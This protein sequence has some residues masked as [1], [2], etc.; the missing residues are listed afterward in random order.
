MTAPPMAKTVDERQGKLRSVSKGY[1]EA[2][3]KWLM[4]QNQRHSMKKAPARI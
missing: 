3:R 2:L 1:R 4:R